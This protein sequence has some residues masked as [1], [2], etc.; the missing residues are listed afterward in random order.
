M[1][2]FDERAY[3]D[4]MALYA[5]GV[6]VVAA[7]DG[8]RI[9]A[10]TVSSFTSVSLAPPLLLICVKQESDFLI[11]ARA[12]RRF[13]LN[14]LRED[15]A[16]LGKLF[17]TAPQDERR[18]ALSAVP[19]GPPRLVDPAGPL[20][21]FNCVLNAEHRAGDHSILVAEPIELEADSHGRPLVW[22]RGRLGPAPE[23][24]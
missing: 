14:I 10:L 6:A 2:S 18:A 24:P 21:R 13:S 1:A 19:G 3:R 5:A 23:A 16:A 15:Q 11:V 9:H 4:A 22:W 20:V 7:D 17:A 8:A 12:A